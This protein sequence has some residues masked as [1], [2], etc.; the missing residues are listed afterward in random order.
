MR[1]EEV[2]SDADYSVVLLDGTSLR[3][4]AN[5]RFDVL[6]SQSP[7]PQLLRASELQ[8][9]DEIL[10][11]RRSS[12][13]ET[14]SELLLEDMDRTL[15]QDEAR[16][17]RTWVVVA[18]AAMATSGLTLDA[19][20]R[21][22][23]SQGINVSRQTIRSWLREDNE[24]TTPRDWTRFLLF[25]REIG[26]ALPEDQLRHYHNSIRRWRV[27]ARKARPCGHTCAAACVFRWSVGFSTWR[28][29]RRSGG[30]AYAT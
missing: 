12:Y 21:K 24:E 17:R 1:V 20:A 26:I 19:V 30:F 8:E 18:Q 2:D 16:A 7:H 28:G 4:N 11:V 25:A 9:G 14:L 10:L 13:Q 5:R 15:L 23:R 22:L 29:F 6:R 27:G 3:V